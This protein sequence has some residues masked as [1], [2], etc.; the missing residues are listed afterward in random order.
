MGMNLKRK[1]RVPTALFLPLYIHWG[2]VY[3]IIIIYM[4]IF[5]IIKKYVH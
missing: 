5:I 4:H 1:I 2:I 3:I